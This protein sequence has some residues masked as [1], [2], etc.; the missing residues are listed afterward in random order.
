[1]I[2]EEYYGRWLVFEINKRIKKK[3]KRTCKLYDE[4]AFK[5]LYH[6][7]DEIAIRFEGGGAARSSVAGQDQ[8]SMT[9][10]VTMV[11]KQEHAKAVRGCVEAFQMEYNAIP[12]SMTYANDEGN[13]ITQ[14]VKS[15]FFTPITIDS[16]GYPTATDTIDVTWL[17]FTISVIYGTTAVSSPAQFFLYLLWDGFAGYFPILPISS[18]NCSSQPAYDPYLAQGGEYRSEQTVIS[19]N[20]AW[21]F[22]IPKLKTGE[23]VQQFLRNEIYGAVGTGLFGQELKLLMIDELGEIEILPRTYQVTEVYENNAAAYNLTF[24]L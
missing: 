9:V 5:P 24:S 6:N 1:M 3:L 18:Y 8:N 14:N 21:S 7:P 23:I 11:F 22:V 4:V 15:V 13:E 2:F 16:N 17:T 10:S 20:R 19:S 12:I